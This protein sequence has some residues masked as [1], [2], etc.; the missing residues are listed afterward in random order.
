MPSIIRLVGA[1]LIGA[2]ALAAS[3]QPVPVKDLFKGYTFNRISLSPDG[4]TIATIFPHSEENNGVHLGLAMSDLNTGVS[5]IVHREKYVSVIDLD[6]AEDNRLLTTLWGGSMRM[7]MYAVNADGTELKEIIKPG[8]PSLLLGA[9]MVTSRSGRP[10]E[11]LMARRKIGDRYER[12]RWHFD[13]Q[14]PLPGVYRLDTR[15]GEHSLA[16]ADPGWSFEWFADRHGVVRVAHGWDKAAFKPNGALIDR[17][18]LPA[19]RLYWIGDDGEA[20]EIPGIKL[21]LGEE[22]DP[23]GFEMEGRRFL[24]AGRQGGDRAAIWAYSP[25][26]GGIEGPLVAND[27]VDVRRAILSPH[28]RTVAGVWIDDGLGRVEWLQPELRKIQGL[29]DQSLRDTRNVFVG[30]GRDFRRVLVFSQSAREPGRYFLYDRPRNSISEIYRS[31]EWLKHA[32]FG[33]TEAIELAARDGTPLHGYLTRPPGA[34]AGRPLPTVLYVHGGPWGIRDYA[35]FD[36]VVQF[37]ATRG[38]AVLQVNFRGSGGY[39]RR[40]EELARRQFGGTMQT[41]LDDAVDWAVAQGHADPR[42]LV[43]AG[44][45]Y[46][47][48]ATLMALIQQPERFRAGIALMPATNLVQQIEDYNRSAPG[49]ENTYAYNWWS[50]WVGDPKTDRALLEAISPIRQ[51]A[52]IRRPVFLAYGEADERIVYEQT[53]E[54]GKALRTLKKTHERYVAKN[55]GHSLYREESRYKIFHALEKFL[56]KHAPAS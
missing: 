22:F 8:E 53:T 24:F 29:V 45:S 3:A 1:A 20:R 23:L 18:T 31:A 15:T 13:G 46:G 50:E 33:E 55:E 12:Q 6:W 26:T 40:F 39:G 41:D 47:G 36:P 21:G 43:I 16:V 19:R 10:G 35:T 32:R 9:N 2:G 54:F 52:R 38:Y 30:W 17:A 11:V 44:A 49:K 7:G 37:F 28:D 42:N 48:Y 56:Q 14:R 4:S 25:D 51:V 5:K 27:R 34:A